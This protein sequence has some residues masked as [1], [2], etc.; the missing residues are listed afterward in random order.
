MAGKAPASPAPPAFIGNDNS[1]LGVIVDRSSFDEEDE[2]GF[3]KDLPLIIDEEQSFSDTDG[4][5]RVMKNGKV[6]RK[7]RWKPP[8]FRRN[9][10]KNNVSS[11]QSVISALST[12]SSSTSR[13][14]STAKSFLS[15]FSRKSQNSFHTFHSTETPVV[16]NSRQSQHTFQR[17]NY[18]DHFDV[19]PEQ[20]ATTTTTTIA[21]EGR[22]IHKKMAPARS[23][24]KFQVIETVDF[25]RS[26]TLPSRLNNTYPISPMSE[27]SLQFLDPFGESE[28]PIPQSPIP[29]SPSSKPSV[30]KAP[31]PPSN[32]RMS[33]SKRPPLFKRSLK[34]GQGRPPASP[35]TAKAVTTVGSA[36]TQTSTT[37][38]SA[39]PLVLSTD[40]AP[41]ITS[42]C[43]HLSD[44]VSLEHQD[45]VLPMLDD[46]EEDRRVAL[47]I[48]TPK[49]SQTD[50]YP[51]PVDPPGTGADNSVQRGSSS[52]S[53]ERSTTNQ[54]LAD[55]G[56]VAAMSHASSSTPTNNLDKSR[57]ASPSPSL[58]STPRR[59]YNRP[60]DTITTGPNG[61]KEASTEETSRRSSVPVDVDDGAFLEA[62]HNLRAIHDMAAEHLAHGEFVE[63][64][65][66][67]EEIL[68][69]QQ[70]RYGNNSYRVGTAL[71]NLGLVH[72]KSGDYEKAIDFCT[73][74]VQVRKEALV[75]NHPDVAVSLA[76]LGVAYLESQNYEKSLISFREALHIRRN[77]L[78]PRHPKCAKV[79]NN[80]GCAL[81]SKEDYD[82]AR[83]AYEEALDIQ[84]DALRMVS[85]DSPEFP[86]AAYNSSLLSVASTLCNLGSIKL[87]RGL[88][89]EAELLLEEALLVSMGFDSEFGASCRVFFSL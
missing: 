38:P 37:D 40:T 50:Y 6:R 54:S 7:L 53:R 16:K 9:K 14:T 41:T 88:Y 60:V 63:A 48:G 43:S 59:R 86:G 12:K 72:M 74:A 17:P 71:H 27:S 65:E 36:M 76:Q 23:N 56:S 10:Q 13:S 8:V 62:E 20:A 84:R 87:K 22:H 85:E 57:P 81:F 25:E 80:I 30:E 31:P 46:A 11:N 58:S 39:A 21:N 2:F 78:G 45:S 35:S 1:Q 3:P 18:Q 33:K 34:L 51:A 28:A 5:A 55:T 32:R 15:H 68:R 52:I 47:C 82:G 67:F 42:S 70:E 4:G 73:R 89:D 44:S 79:L 83:V 29:Q 69:G 24:K 61:S 19:G 49:R 66:V 75:P 64:I 77:F 26:N